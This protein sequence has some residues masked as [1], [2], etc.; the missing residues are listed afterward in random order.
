MVDNSRF[1]I[2]SAALASMISCTATFTPASARQEEDRPSPSPT[3][4]IRK[5][6]PYA[7]DGKNF[8]VKLSVICY[9]DTKHTGECTEDDEETVKSLKI[10]DE[11]GKTRF[12][13]SFPVAFAHQAERH[14]VEVMRLEGQ[15]HQA[16]EVRYEK[17]PSHSNTGETMQLFG[18]R[19][20]MLQ[21]FNREP[22]DFNGELG[23]LPAGTSK[24]SRRL[25]ARDLLPIYLV[26]NY[27]YILEP[28]RVDWN[29]FALKPQ[30][31]GEFEVAQ[32]SPYSRKPD[33][34]GEGYIHLYASPDQKSAAVGM[35]VSPRSHVQVLSALFAA[36]PEENS[37]ANDTWLK[38]S[39]DG[40]PGWILG[41]ADYTAIGVTAMQ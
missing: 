8:T 21:A 39:I 14:V 3:H 34:E 26:T 33:I 15:D 12:E 11:A 5:L 22:L 41:L 4:Y 13:K 9:K 16:L 6:G 37:S 10:E 29:D 32:E 23:E 19:D 25:L 31:S 28:V 24:D 2:L 40:K 35:S 1:L 30:E 38:I 17:L 7:I 18:V 36:N 27:F 20:G